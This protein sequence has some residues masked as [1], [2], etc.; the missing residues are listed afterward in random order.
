LVSPCWLQPPS[1]TNKPFKPVRCS[2]AG[3]QKIEETGNVLSEIESQGF[4]EQR[5]SAPK[6]TE[7]ERDTRKGDDIISL[8]DTSSRKSRRKAG[9]KGLPE[10]CD[11]TGITGRPGV[12]GKPLRRNESSRPE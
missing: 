3:V 11:V 4:R 12:A 10:V 1:T 5:A 6:G 8:K 9:K 2:S 7:N